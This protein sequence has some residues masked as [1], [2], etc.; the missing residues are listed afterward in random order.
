MPPV[1]LLLGSY[2]GNIVTMSSC[3]HVHEIILARLEARNGDLKGRV[4]KL[5]VSSITTWQPLRRTRSSAT[6]ARITSEV[7]EDTLNL[8]AMSKI[9]FL[10]LLLSLFGP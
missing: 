6:R 2:D 10:A 4:L 7:V 9:I 5:F 1:A 8:E 3:R